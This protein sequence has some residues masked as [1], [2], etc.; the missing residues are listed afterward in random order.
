MADNSG[1]KY[2]R[3]RYLGNIWLLSVMCVFIFNADVI[4]N[5][6]PVD[7][8][9]FAAR[10]QGSN[11]SQARQTFYSCYRETS[12]GIVVSFPSIMVKYMILTGEIVFFKFKN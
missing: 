10:S 5:Y 9:V 3:W 1:D 8:H 11:N 7:G 4:L 2:L 12:N 6:K